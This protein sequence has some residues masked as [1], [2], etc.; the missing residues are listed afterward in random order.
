MEY[1]MLITGPFPNR[2]HPAMLQLKPLP[3]ITPRNQTTLQ[4][5]NQEQKNQGNLA[6]G[7]LPMQ[8][9]QIIKVVSSLQTWRIR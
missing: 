7:K 6:A 4:C 5:R 1:D 2:Q 3:K 9:T 8:R